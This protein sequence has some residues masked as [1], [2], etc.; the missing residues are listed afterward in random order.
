MAKAIFLFITIAVSTLMLVLT[1][2]LVMEWGEST[3][4][5]VLGGG[6]LI[7]FQLILDL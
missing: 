4:W 5:W 1:G 6:K 2:V 7:H 3:I